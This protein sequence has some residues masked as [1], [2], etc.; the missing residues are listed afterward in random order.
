MIARRRSSH[1]SPSGNKVHTM[2]T[3]PTDIFD[4]TLYEDVRLP[5][6]QAAGLPFYTY[7]SPEWYERE[8]ERIFFK[9]WIFACRTDEIPERGDYVFVEFLNGPIV[10]LHA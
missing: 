1:G 4:P 10:G 7:T 3:A 6:M 9:E 5:P 8:V 2:T